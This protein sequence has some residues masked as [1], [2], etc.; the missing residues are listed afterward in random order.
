[1]ALEVV[2]GVYAFTVVGSSPVVENVDI[3][4]NT[5]WMQVFPLIHSQEIFYCMPMTYLMGL[6]DRAQSRNP[7]CRIRGFCR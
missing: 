6:T 3:H 1:M 4:V 7:R 5:L 2:I